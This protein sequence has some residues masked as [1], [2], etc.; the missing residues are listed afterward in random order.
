VRAVADFGGGL[1]DHGFS[2]DRCPRALGGKQLGGWPIP[3]LPSVMTAIL[4]A[5]LDILSFTSR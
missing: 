1:L 3:L 2:A 4:P 5:S